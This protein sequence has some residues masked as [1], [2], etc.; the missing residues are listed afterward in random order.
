MLI[1]PFILAVAAALSIC[2][3][4][5]ASLFA[6]RVGGVLDHPNERSSHTVA[7]P[8]TGGIAI[9]TAWVAGI[10]V[11]AVFSESG[12][13]ARD[14]G[15]MAVAAL[16][17]LGVGYADD[18][19]ELAPVWKLV[20]Q[21]AVATIFVVL[22][23][24]LKGFPLPYVGQVELAPLLGVVISIF[25]I[26]AFMNIYNFM[27][28]ANGLAAGTAVVGLAW[29]SI[30]AS[31]AGA[32]ILGAAALLLALS[33]TGFLPENLRRGRLFMGD[34]GS[35]VVGFLIAA[36]AILG[37]NW[38]ESRL[39][40]LFVPIIFSPLVFDVGWTLVSRLIRKQN[41]LR[42]HREHLYQ[43]LIRSGVSHAN[44]AIIYMSLVSLASAAAIL[45]LALPTSLH[46]LVPAMTAIC[47]AVGA[48]VIYKKAYEQGLLAQQR[49]L[50]PEGAT[51]PAE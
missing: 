5:C 22:F 15:F 1:E 50:N 36:F 47:F 26:V 42:A 24:P 6:A 29:I 33:A 37:A 45:M 12:V 40:M 35:Q 10:F 7:T 28:G 43:L 4:Y 48:T 9:F 34:N 25:W 49:S 38:T 2:V 51:Q 46:W 31:F 13:L 41:I 16:A 44:V 21:I 11:V 19:I 27:D 14:L 8:R 17:A 32:P 20:G 30:M 39:S 3:A 18:Q 23:G